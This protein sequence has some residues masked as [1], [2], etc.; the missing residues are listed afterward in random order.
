MFALIL[1]SPSLINGGVGLARGSQLGASR[2]NIASVDSSRCVM[3]AP[4]AARPRA[5]L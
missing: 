2:V 5:R 3:R 1:C 4:H